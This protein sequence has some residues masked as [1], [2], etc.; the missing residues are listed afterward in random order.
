MET[1]SA[2]NKTTVLRLLQS[3]SKRTAEATLSQKAIQPKCR[4]PVE[5]VGVRSESEQGLG[6]GVNVSSAVPR[7]DEL[8]LDLRVQGGVGDV[9]NKSNADRIQDVCVCVG[10]PGVGG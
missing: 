10:G 2:E 5:S 3:V 9:Q 1:E 4:K 7:I 8:H 6:G